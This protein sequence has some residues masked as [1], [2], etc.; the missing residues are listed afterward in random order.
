[1]SV[2]ADFVYQTT[3]ISNSSQWLQF[4]SDNEIE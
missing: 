1:M 2:V 3:P 4:K